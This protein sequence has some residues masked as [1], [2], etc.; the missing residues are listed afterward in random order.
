MITVTTN[1]V[2]ALMIVTQGLEPVPAYPQR[3]MVLKLDGSSYAELREEAKTSA[4]AKAVQDSILAQCQSVQVGPANEVETLY[5]PVCRTNFVFGS[6]LAG[7]AGDCY[8][9]HI[10]RDKAPPKWQPKK[11]EDGK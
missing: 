6:M 9:V 7:S 8:A 2:V 11:K 4:Y 10:G 3:Q 1:M 5:R